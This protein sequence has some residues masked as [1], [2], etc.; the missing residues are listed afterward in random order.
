[1][2]WLIESSLRL[3]LLVL[4]LAFALIAIGIRFAESIPLDVFPEFAPPLVEIQTEAPG[5]STEDVERLVT[6]PIEIGR[7]HV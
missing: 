2:G 5:I 7:A 1:M 6:I 4:L 3:R